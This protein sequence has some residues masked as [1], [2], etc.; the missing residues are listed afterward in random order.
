MELNREQ[1][2]D[3]ILDEYHHGSNS[4]GDY[5]LKTIL[6]D[7][8]IMLEQKKELLEALGP[9][10]RAYKEVSVSQNFSLMEKEFSDFR[11]KM[12]IR[13]RAATSVFTLSEW[14]ENRVKED[15]F[16]SFCN[17]EIK[18]GMKLTK[19]LTK[20]SK[21]PSF[22]FSD[23]TLDEIHT[24]YSQILNE[25]ET[26]GYLIVSANPIDFLL[27]SRG[28]NWTSCMSIG[29][30]YDSGPLSYA[31]D[32]RSL[33]AFLISSKDIKAFQEGKSVGKKW[34]KI[35]IL[36]KDFKEVPGLIAS[37]G[38]PFQSESLTVES[39]TFISELFFKDKPLNEW[40]DYSKPSVRPLMSFRRE[41][42]GAQLYSD[43]APRNNI[44][45]FYNSEFLHSL[46]IETEEQAK[47]RGVIFRF[48]YG[49]PI[50]CYATGCYSGLYA[51]DRG[52]VCLSCSPNSET[53]ELCS[54]EED[55][56]LIY[57][58]YDGTQVCEF[59]FAE[60][61]G[62]AENDG[63]FYLLDDLV[64]LEDKNG[65]YTELWAESNAFSCDNC[66]YY[67]SN[68][69][70]SSGNNCVDCRPNGEE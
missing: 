4:H 39:A 66:G 36:D 52:A 29:H 70:K 28:Q 7:V 9:D 32:Q 35:F 11:S 10:G 1:I 42:S 22:N 40:C 63:E 48:R 37:K 41:A 56:D 26:N 55:E 2:A 64:F 68:D 60:E 18:A 45:F 21:S 12:G 25:K 20:I 54:C 13:F 51:D 24:S 23:S 57:Y 17:L 38:Y 67:F 58:L 27:M 59:C 49:V 47:E 65:F 14:I 43:I 50:K 30:E 31:K 6:S 61:C 3:I 5:S 16:I 62:M 34:R 33:I 19:A 44:L 15:K 46:G 8:D 53:C 69:A